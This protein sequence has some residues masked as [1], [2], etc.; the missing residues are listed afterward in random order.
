MVEPYGRLVAPRRIV[1]HM[2]EL[3]QSRHEPHRHDSAACWFRPERDRTDTRVSDQPPD[4][5][6][7]TKGAGGDTR[8]GAAATFRWAVRAQILT[9]RL[10]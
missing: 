8:P 7:H 4:A 10:T 2:G 3:R 5:T 1:T 6:H 9:Y